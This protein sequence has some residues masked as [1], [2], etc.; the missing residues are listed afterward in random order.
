MCR[1]TLEEKLT[2]LDVITARPRPFQL[3]K[4]YVKQGRIPFM[5]TGGPGNTKS[6][7]L[8]RVLSSHIYAAIVVDSGLWR[9]VK[10]YHARKRAK[11]FVTPLYYLTVPLKFLH[12][13]LP[14]SDISLAISSWERSRL[15]F[16]VFLR[17]NKGVQPPQPTPLDPLL[18]AV[19]GIHTV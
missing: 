8:V 17:E 7:L 2:I 3:C 16:V 13:Y 5:E 9:Y 15:S 18:T 11:F 12:T 10:K 6:Y 19:L 14:I 4:T 1:H